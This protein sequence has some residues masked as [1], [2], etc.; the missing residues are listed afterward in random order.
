MCSCCAACAVH[1]LLPGSRAGVLTPTFSGL[2]H[3]QGAVAEGV[4]TSRSAHHLAL[5]KGIDCPVIS[6]IYQCAWRGRAG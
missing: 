4:L 2:D 5:K 6:G 1:A 3:G